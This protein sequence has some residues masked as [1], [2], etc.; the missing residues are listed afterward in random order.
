MLGS[1]LVVGFG[2]VAAPL[3]WMGRGGHVEVLKSNDVVSCFLHIVVV[4][5]M[6]VDVFHHLIEDFH[7]FS[8]LFF[9]QK[10]GVLHG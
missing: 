3:R 5:V 4:V 7:D 2:R 8:F 1:C 10:T 6:N 9:F